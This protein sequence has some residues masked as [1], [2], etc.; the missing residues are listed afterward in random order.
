MGTA[1]EGESFFARRWP[2]ARAVS[3]PSQELYAAFDLGRASLG[4]IAG[5][6]LF[7][8][9]LRT[10]LAGHLPGRPIGDPWVMSG[11]FLVRDGEV[12]WR[13]QHAHSADP[14]RWDELAAAA[15]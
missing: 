6:A 5:P 11:W 4:Q 9:G 15:G 10:V 13:Q 2:E 12:R 14:R 7:G 8:A 1:L 3:D